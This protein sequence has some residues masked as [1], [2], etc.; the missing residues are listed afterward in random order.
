MAK[1]RNW[2]KE[3]AARKEY[4]KA[5]RKKN[6]DKDASRTAAR[7]KLKCGKGKEID[8]KDSN[9]K[10]NNRSNLKCIAVRKTALKAHVKPTQNDDSFVCLLYTSPSPRDRTRSRMPSSA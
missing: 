6:K 9:P 2:K 1:S 3:Y 8:H 10:N 7:R 5:Y 4:L